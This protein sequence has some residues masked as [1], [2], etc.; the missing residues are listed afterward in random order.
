[1]G[2]AAALHVMAAAGTGLRP[3]AALEVWHLLVVTGVL[4]SGLAYTLQVMAQRKVSAGRAVVILAG[5]S[6]AAAIFS[7]VWVGD[8][9]AI[10]QWVG[11]LVVLAA[12]AISELGARRAAALRIDPAT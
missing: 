7:A 6:V 11:A 8:R 5:E 1:M 9:L 12:M 10:H 2:A 3:A 4:G